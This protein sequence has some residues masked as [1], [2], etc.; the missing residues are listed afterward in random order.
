MTGVGLEVMMRPVVCG[1]LSDIP[2]EHV[3]FPPSS[4]STNTPSE[5]ASG[6][7][8]NPD[9]GHMFFQNLD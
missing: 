1:K 7:L 2:E 5:K 6:L 9:G 3:A 4:E 8:C